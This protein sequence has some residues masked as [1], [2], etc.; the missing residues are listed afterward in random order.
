MSLRKAAGS[1]DEP[2]GLLGSEGVGSVVVLHNCVSPVTAH[3]PFLEPG[4]SSVFTVFKVSHSES[5]QNVCIRV[6]TTSRGLVAAAARP[7]ANPP[8]VNCVKKV[9]SSTRP[10]SSLEVNGPPQRC[11]PIFVNREVHRG[12]RDVHG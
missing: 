11:S 10:F 2:Y 5:S 12:E 9:S 4:C 3:T 1:D 6:F 8:A 7:P